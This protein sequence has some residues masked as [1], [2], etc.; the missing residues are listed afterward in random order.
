MAMMIAK[1]SGGKIKDGLKTVHRMVTSDAAFRTLCAE[2]LA[3]FAEG[4]LPGDLGDT[5]EAV[6]TGECGNARETSGGLSLVLH[7]AS[8]LH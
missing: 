7:A 8:P 1:S 4:R 3:G 2:A 5:P 6:E